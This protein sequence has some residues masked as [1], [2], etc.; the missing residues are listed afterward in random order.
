MKP[1]ESREVPAQSPKERL[2]ALARAGLL[3]GVVAALALAAC[4]RPSVTLE[5][6]WWALAVSN[7]LLLVAAPGLLALGMARRAGSSLFLLVCFLAWQFLAP[8]VGGS[9]DSYRTWASQL[10]WLSFAGVFLATSIAL[11]TSWSWRTL[12]WSV[13]GL[14]GGLSLY[15]LVEYRSGQQERLLSTF[16]NAD[17]FSLYPLVAIFLGLGLFHR[18]GAQQRLLIHAN[19][20]FQLLALLLTGARATVVGLLAGVIV[21]GWLL[22]RRKARKGAH[23]VVETLAPLIMAL[24]LLLL[25]SLFILPGSKRWERLLTGGET[26]GLAM[27]RDVLLHGARAALQ[28]P[29]FGSGPGTF[30]LRYQE[31]RPFSEVP[32][33]VYVN[34]AHNDYIELLVESGI[35]ALILWLCLLLTVFETVLRSMRRNPLA[36][37]YSGAAA[38]LASIGVYQV[39]N[40]AIPVLA[41]LLL[42]ALLMAM[43]ACS[44]DPSTEDKGNARAQRFFLVI[45]G[46]ALMAGLWG[47][48]SSLQAQLAYR[49][50][51]SAEQA[52][53][54]LE[55]E[56]AEELFQG[57]LARVPHRAHGWLKLARTQAM[58]QELTPSPELAARHLVSLEKAY[59]SSPR[60]M[61]VASTWAR[62]LAEAERTD[63]AIQVLQQAVSTMGYF[64]PLRRELVT[65]YL[66][67]GDIVQATETQLR[68]YEKDKETL[69][70]TAALLGAAEM[71]VPESTEKLLAQV[72]I[73]LEDLE[74]LIKETVTRMVN[75]RRF[76]EADRVSKVWGQLRGEDSCFWLERSEIWTKASKPEMELKCLE[77]A[78]EER[79]LSS[80][81]YERALLRYVEVASANGK[82][83]TAEARLSA[84]IDRGSAGSPAI[85][86]LARLQLQKGQLAACRKLIVAGL[87]Q[88]PRDPHLL[89]VRGELSF[90][91]GFYESAREDAMDVLEMVPEHAGARKLLAQL[92]E[93]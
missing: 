75:G 13:L 57:S 68:L 54:S 3:M 27:R 70:R 71:A 77:R 53:A 4:L 88:Y 25:S 74:P 52:L 45:S 9:L 14:S 79:N 16:V 82:A 36:Y 72:P 80:T 49:Q 73:A 67:K 1:S 26:Q 17:C 8:Q 44:I 18:A 28:Q 93:R 87:E 21:Q 62:G 40:F 35:P 66:K 15:G 12:A 34:V 83:K 31:V 6:P 33:R 65:L 46:L 2:Q 91:E 56:K 92:R 78:V 51:K 58:L 64:Q 19:T 22:S 11:R 55:L 59:Q 69:K 24:F 60:Q 90:K 32:D 29:L 20:V 84:Y 42:I 61:E 76:T 7:F 86:S 30:A 85:A 23:P 81:C 39:L 89:V 41:D 37:E 38:A 63:E 50:A 10:H 47:S 5:P 43:C 48:Y